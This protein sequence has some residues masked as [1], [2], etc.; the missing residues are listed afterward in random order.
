MD[1]VLDLDWDF[2][3]SGDIDFDWDSRGDGLGGP[4]W[5]LLCVFSAVFDFEFDCESVF[6]LE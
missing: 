1:A 3:F 4:L 2:D 6:D 5:L